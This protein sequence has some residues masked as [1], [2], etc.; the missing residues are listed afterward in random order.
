MEAAREGAAMEAEKW[1]ERLAAATAEAARERK[2]VERLQQELRAARRG[3]PWTPKAAEVRRRRLFLTA[4]F[5]ACAPPVNPC[6]HPLLFCL[7]SSAS[8]LGISL[9]LSKVLP[10]RSAVLSFMGSTALECRFPHYAYCRSHLGLQ[11]L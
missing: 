6:R 10:D 2:E 8:V 4:Q 5:P 1:A 3:V 7:V 9:S 11:C